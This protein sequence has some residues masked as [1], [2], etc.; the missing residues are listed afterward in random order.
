MPADG[1][2]RRDDVTPN[3]PDLRVGIGG[4]GAIGRQ[5]AEALDRG[6]EGLVLVAVSARDRTRAAGKVAGFTRPPAIVSLAELAEHADAI[7]EC[8]P[9][10][11]F[12]EH[13]APALRPS[14]ILY[15]SR[16]AA[17]LHRVHLIALASA[18]GPRII[19]TPS[20]L[21]GLASPPAL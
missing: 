5:L 2:A 20:P 11:V 16:V 14:R 12:E 19:V 18:T 6:V 9:S 10:P 1:A 13:A 17:L 8:P 7:V 15:P 3:R 21:P 4:L